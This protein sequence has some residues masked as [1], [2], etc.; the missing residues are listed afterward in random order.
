MAHQAYL[1]NISILFLQT[2]LQ[3]FSTGCS[4]A[5]LVFLQFLEQATLSPTPEPLHVLCPLPGNFP[6]FPMTKRRKCLPV[7]QVS[8]YISSPQRICPNYHIQSSQLEAI[9]IKL[10]VGFSP[11]IYCNLQICICDILPPSGIYAS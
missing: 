1:K 7:R 5:S 2:Y 9:H 4:L 3:L 6:T 11:S 8:V 10:L